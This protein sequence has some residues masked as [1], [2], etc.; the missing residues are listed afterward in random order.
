MNVAFLIYN[1]PA[2]TER[3]FAEI[4][5]ARP[6]RLLIVADGPRI[7][8]PVDAKKVEAVR[9][10]VE[11]VDW[12][13]EV[14]R[15]YSDTNLGCRR[16]VSSGLDWVFRTV[17]EAVILEDDCLPH[18]DF[19]LFCVELLARYR[20]DG[21]VGHICG[22]NFDPHSGH[23]GES[24]FFSRYAS[25]WG[26]ATWRRAWRDYDVDMRRWPEVKMSKRHHSFLPSR[27]DWRYFENCWDEVTARRIDTWD[28]Q[29]GFATLLNGR[30]AVRPSVNLVSNIGFGAGDAS[31]TTFGHVAG[32]RPTY[33]M[34]FPLVH[35]ASVEVDRQSDRRVA[36][37]FFK[38]VPEWRRGLDRTVLNPHWY[39][40]VVRCVPIVGRLWAGWR[41]RVEVPQKGETR[42]A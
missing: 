39:G 20:N 38:T 17:D 3:V 34:Q 23:R 36:R 2:L 6:D 18:P 42:R 25:I 33:P 4:R 37:M 1:R 29:W 19:F 32:N 41:R 22:T 30:I 24:Y 7:G 14:S 15:N 12:P 27:T 16:R 13:C 21:R 5:R 11:R 31:H 40:T 26:W 28:A 8:Q 35:P 9:S 10:V